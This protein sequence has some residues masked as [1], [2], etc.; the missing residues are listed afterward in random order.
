ML[1]YSSHLK[2]QTFILPSASA[3]WH[4]YSDCEIHSKLPSLHLHYSEL[5]VGQCILVLCQ[6]H[7]EKGACALHMCA[8]HKILIPVLSCVVLFIKYFTNEHSM[9]G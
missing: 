8:A 4:T 1:G 6:K 9:P 5:L 3:A 7:T 2:K